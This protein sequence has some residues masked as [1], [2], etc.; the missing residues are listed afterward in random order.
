MVVPAGDMAE[1]R[2]G[3][4]PT[5]TRGPRPTG[6]HPTGTGGAWPTGSWPTGTR[7]TKSHGPR[8]TGQVDDDTMSIQPIEPEA[9]FVRRGLAVDYHLAPRKESDGEN[10]AELEETKEEK[11][12]RKQREKEEK[13]SK[14]HHSTGYA[15]PTGTGRP[16]SSRPHSTGYPR[17][18]KSH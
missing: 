14:K 5:K 8:P 9:P 4:H 2:L 1:P 3:V 10:D 7:P 15:G 16:H 6:V 12:A 18:T 17:P 13:K 11:K